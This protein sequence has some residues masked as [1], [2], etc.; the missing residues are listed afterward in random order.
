MTLTQMTGVLLCVLGVSVY[1]S[2]NSGSPN[3]FDADNGSTVA[4][5]GSTSVLNK[6]G[7][8]FE[9][10]GGTSVFDV[11]GRTNVSESTGSE[12]MKRDKLKKT[13]KLKHD[14]F[15]RGRVLDRVAQT[16]FVIC[17]YLHKINTIQ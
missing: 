4:F 5:A 6:C 9:F 10:A 13:R 17:W 12:V 14:Y 2:V 11:V 15:G 16:P 1:T 7:I 3:V 8:P